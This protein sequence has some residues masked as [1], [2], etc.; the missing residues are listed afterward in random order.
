MAIE[1]LLKNIKKS[2]FIRFIIAGSTNTAISYLIYLILLTQLSYT[3][4]YTIS[5]ICG[6]LISYFMGR[7]FIFKEHNGILTI[8]TIPFIYITQ[9]LFGMVIIWLW[10]DTLGMPIYLAP[11]LVTILS[12]PMTYIMT[13][14]AF[15]KNKF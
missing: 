15:V 9:Y 10:I 6:I 5:Y 14:I 7:K 4:S 11:V 8:L 12:L 1:M 3:W 13:R 2:T